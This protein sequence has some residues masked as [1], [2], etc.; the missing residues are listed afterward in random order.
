MF[1]LR[2]VFY[3]EINLRLCNQK[4][5]GESGNFSTLLKQSKP[6]HLVFFVNKFQCTCNSIFNLI[7]FH[8][9]DN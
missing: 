6:S 1:L 4:H 9:V 2:F 3:F 8:I 5:Y 7:F